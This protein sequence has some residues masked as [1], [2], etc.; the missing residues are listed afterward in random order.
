MFRNLLPEI[1][2]I[3]SLKVASL[4]IFFTIFT[5]VLIMVYRMSRNHV[6]HMENLPL[7]NSDFESQRLGDSTN[8]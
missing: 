8:G 4:L 1:A 3:A 5:A 7:D 6:Q 2:G